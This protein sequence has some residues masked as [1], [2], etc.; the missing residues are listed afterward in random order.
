MAKSITFGEDVVTK[1][2]YRYRAAAGFSSDLSTTSS[3]DVFEISA[4]VDDY[5]IFGLNYN[6]SSTNFYMWN[7]VKFNID[8]A[9]VADT[10]TVTWE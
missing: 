3:F 7:D 10:F 8:T 9:V 6:S 1:Y 5:V 4:A 2:L